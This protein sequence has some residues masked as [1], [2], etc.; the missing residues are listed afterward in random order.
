MPREAPKFYAWIDLETTGLDIKRDWIVECSMI[1]TSPDLLT[2]YI[3]YSAVVQPPEGYWGGQ[4]W[5]DRIDNNEFVRD[6]HMK[7]GLLPILYRVAGVPYFDVE[8][9]LI[10]MMEQ[11]VK[12]KKTVIVAGTGVAGFDL[13]VIQ[14]QWPTLAEWFDYYCMDIGPVRRLFKYTCNRE[15]LLPEEADENH[16]SLSDVRNA[17]EQAR[18]FAHIIEIMPPRSTDKT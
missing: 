12:E 7:N 9:S 14:N 3:S 4:S 2:E 16:R 13:P 1:L 15:D 11:F 6:M 5:R 18:H 17:L 8:R 10:S